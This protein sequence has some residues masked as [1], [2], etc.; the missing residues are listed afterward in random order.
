MLHRIVDKFLNDHKNE[1]NENDKLMQFLFKCIDKFGR[2]ASVL[3]TNVN[4]SNEK[5]EYL[6]RLI[7]DLDGKFDFHFINSSFM[8]S[9]Y[10]NQSEIIRKEEQNQLKYDELLGNIEKTINEIKS[11]YINQSLK[12]R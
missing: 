3:F 4:F 6:N 8:K 2:S 9:F 5:A 12:L 11:E 10:Q 7:F 1:N